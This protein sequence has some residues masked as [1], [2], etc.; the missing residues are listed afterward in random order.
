[1]TQR[2]IPIHLA[3]YPQLKKNSPATHHK[4][5]I[6]LL[7]LCVYVGKE[8]RKGEVSTIPQ[9]LLRRLKTCKIHAKPVWIKKNREKGER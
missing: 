1:L 5:R 7:L 3:S 2:A 4:I 8:G 9:R 6:I